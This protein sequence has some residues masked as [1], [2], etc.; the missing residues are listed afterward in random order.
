MGNQE[1]TSNVARMIGSSIYPKKILIAID[2]SEKAKRALET[3]IE[4]AVKNNSE[5]L[6]E[7][8][9]WTDKYGFHR[10]G[11]YEGDAQKLVNSAVSLAKDRGIKFVRGIVKK[12]T[13]SVT[14]PIIDWASDEHVDLIVTGSRGLGRFKR[15]LLGSVSQ[16]VMTHA[17]CKVLVAS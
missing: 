10:G 11:L 2:G 5:L 8:V 4:L 12:G 1:E 13:F 14:E 3:G 6:I 17:P 9:V 15:L 16:Q 7:T